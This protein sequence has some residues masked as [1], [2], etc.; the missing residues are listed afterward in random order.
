V[1]AGQFKTLVSLVEKAGLVETL[2]S[3]GPFT[4]F[5]PTDAAF[6][7][8][9]ATLV[10]Q[11]LNNPAQLK[12]VLLYHVLSGEV[13]AAQATKIAQ[14]SCGSNEVVTV[15]GQ[16]ISLSLQG[17]DL[18]VNQSRVTEADVLAENG[19]IHVIDTVLV[20]KL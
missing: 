17:G 2:K 1:A 8:L 9:P 14:N 3:K 10:N 12:A 5:A 19:V 16:D 13:L 11:L 18:Y 4:V 7:K 6:A 20:P 15:N